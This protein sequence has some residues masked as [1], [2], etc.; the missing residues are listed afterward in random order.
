MFVFEKRLTTRYRYPGCE[1][2]AHILFLFVSFL[3]SIAF[4]EPGHRVKCLDVQVFSVC[5]VD[6]VQKIP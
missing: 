2:N 3:A 5:T 1:K 6:A 4:N